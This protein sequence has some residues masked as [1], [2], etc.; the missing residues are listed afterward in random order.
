MLEHGICNLHKYRNK[1]SYCSE[2]QTMLFVLVINFKMPTIVGI[3]KFMTRTNNMVICL[4]HEISFITSVPYR[5]EWEW[6]EHQKWGP[7]SLAWVQPHTFKEDLFCLPLIQVMKLSVKETRSV[8]MNVFR[9]KYF[10]FIS[11]VK[12]ELSY[13]FTINMFSTAENCMEKWIIL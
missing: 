1:W 6:Y 8:T 9:K 7:V 11:F 10:L 13:V 12:I 5:S 2:Q 4:K 3:L